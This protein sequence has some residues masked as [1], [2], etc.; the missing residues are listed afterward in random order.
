MRHL[1]VGHTEPLRVEL[2]SF[3]TSLAAGTQPAVTGED[4]LISLDIAMRCLGERAPAGAK[5]EDFAAP[6]ARLVR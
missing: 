5:V 2:T 6:K 1:P 4:G 3:L